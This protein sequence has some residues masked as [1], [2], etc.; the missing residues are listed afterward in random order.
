MGQTNE[1]VELRPID[2]VAENPDVIAISGDFKYEPVDSESIKKFE[3]KLKKS[4]DDLQEFICSICFSH[5]NEQ[6][7]CVKLSCHCKNTICEP[8][9]TT[10]IASGN[11]CPFCRTPIIRENCILSTTMTQ[12][13]THV[14]KIVD[15]LSGDFDNR[16]PD[17]EETELDEALGAEDRIIEVEVDLKRL[18]KKYKKRGDMII[19]LEQ[20]IEKLKKKLKKRK[21]EE[22]DEKKEK[23]KRKFG[24]SGRLE[25]K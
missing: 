12:M 25:D 1:K 22:I 23:K 8:C 5:Y 13:S 3:T 21:R 4:T 24:G 17:N 16:E 2:V 11:T 14:K 15:E 20:K 10:Q 19:V 18:K 6:R 7:S 9:L